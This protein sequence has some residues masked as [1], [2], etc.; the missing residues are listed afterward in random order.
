MDTS[1]SVQS[2]DSGAL[3]ELFEEIKIVWD[4]WALI[5]ILFQL[6]VLN[7]YFFQRCM[8][9]FRCEMIQA[10]RGAILINQL[11]EKEMREQ[12]EQQRKK[13][14]EIKQRTAD[15]RARYEAQQELVDKQRALHG[16][17]RGRSL[18]AFTP[19]TYGQGELRFDL[20]Y[21]ARAKKAVIFPHSVFT[22]P[23]LY[24]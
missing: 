14:Q 22:N 11:I 18:A 6:R 9:E 21:L 15:I 8:I 4:T 12:E 19:Q 1:C 5:F 10:K 7:S 3:G 20:G 24:V 16:G 2:S 13:L 17:P 23:M